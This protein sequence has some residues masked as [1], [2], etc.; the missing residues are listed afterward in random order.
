MD[1]HRTSIQPEV[2]YVRVCVCVCVCVYIQ[3]IACLEGIRSTSDLFHAAVDAVSE[4][5]WCTVDQAT[6]MID[7]NMMPLIQV[8]YATH[9]THIPQ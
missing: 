4:L 6:G 1:M 3:V 5:V 8:S 9:N 7:T 2:T